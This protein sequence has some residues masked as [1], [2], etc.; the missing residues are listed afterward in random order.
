M[1]LGEC[2]HIVLPLEV[3][4][5]DRGSHAHT[6]RKDAHAH[7]YVRASGACHSSERSSAGAESSAGA[8]TD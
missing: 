2:S 4:L 1:R 8:A 7:R 3:E 6:G 5:Q